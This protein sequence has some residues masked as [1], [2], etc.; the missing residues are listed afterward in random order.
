MRG[1][2]GDFSHVVLR[3]LVFVLVLGHSGAWASREVTN[4]HVP[5]AFNAKPRSLQIRAVFPISEE[6]FSEFWVVGVENNVSTMYRVKDG[7]WSAEDPVPDIGIIS[8]IVMSDK[9][10]GWAIGTK[11]ILEYDGIFWRKKVSHANRPVFGGEL[12]SQVSENEVWFGNEYR[13]KDGVFEEME[14]EASTYISTISMRDSL[15]GVILNGNGIYKTSD[16]INWEKRRSSP[17]ECWNIGLDDSLAIWFNQESTHGLYFQDDSKQDHIVFSATYL[18]FV[19]LVGGEAWF[20]GSFGTH[21]WGFLRNPELARYSIADG[22]WKLNSAPNQFRASPSR[23]PIIKKL[24][25][26][27]H[28]VIATFLSFNLM[29]EVA[30]FASPSLSAATDLHLDSLPLSDLPAVG[31]KLLHALTLAN[32]GDGYLELKD[33]SINGDMFFIQPGTYTLSKRAEYDRLQGKIFVPAHDSLRIVI[34]Y[35]P[36]DQGFHTGSLTVQTNDPINPVWTVEITAASAGTKGPLIEAPPVVDFGRVLLGGSKQEVLRIGNT[37]NHTLNIL[38]IQSVDF[39]FSIASLPDTVRIQ[40]GAERDFEIEFVPSDTSSH[41]SQIEVLSDDPIRPS[42]IVSVQGKGSPIPPPYLILDSGNISPT[43]GKDDKDIILVVTGDFP[44]SNAEIDNTQVVIQD[45]TIMVEM[46]TRWVGDFPGPVDAQVTS[47]RIEENLG[48]L[49]V[50]TYS[51]QA[52]INGK[53][54]ISSTLRI[55]P[56]NISRGLI[57]IDFNLDEGD[58]GQRIIGN[59]QPGKVVKVQLNMAKGLEI[60]GWSVTVDYDPEQVSYKSSSFSPSDY[61]KGFMPLVDEQPG[62]VSVGGAVLGESESR[63]GEGVLAEF[64]FEALEGFAGTTELV[65]IENNFRFD[66]GGSERYVVQSVATI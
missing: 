11:G 24:T 46:A 37:G 13:M 15:N 19:K 33:I 58:Q 9:N 7:Q 12:I 4:W 44:A 43:S 57:S 28:F 23:D 38:S 45:S 27:P 60:N 64:A 54:A 65:I 49:G 61:L 50:G 21:P 16:G 31:E 40:P 29:P 18:R 42:V 30:F 66:G 14:F 62:Q 32:D 5:E 53:E 48:R 63:S 22:T 8:D 25:V 35:I 17:G 2:G 20:T 52:S 34:A 59:V 55:S 10:R 56:R 1:K 47:W 6:D 3:S 51:V 39:S 36:P 41:Q 26:T